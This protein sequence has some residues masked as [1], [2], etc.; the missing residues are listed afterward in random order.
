M[1][2]PGFWDFE[3]RHQKLASKKDLLVCLDEMIPWAEFRPILESVYA[4]SRKR[5]AGRPPID[6][7][8]M[9][10]LLILQQLYN[11]GDDELEYQVNAQL[12]R[13][14]AEKNKLGNRR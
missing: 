13:L 3:T 12:G 5:K 9:F 11:I 10:K 2:Q 1:G 7:I 8:V 6:V 4:K 14:R